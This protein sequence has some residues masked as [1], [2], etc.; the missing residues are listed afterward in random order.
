MS[1]S[2]FTN[3][4]TQLSTNVEVKSDQDMLTLKIPESEL[5]GWTDTLKKLEDFGPCV[6][7]SHTA[8][9]RNTENLF[10]VIYHFAFPVENKVFRLVS[11]IDRNQ[12]ELSS[13]SHLWACAE[14][15]ERE[16]YDLFGIKYKNHPDLRRVFLDDDWEGFPLRKDYKDPFMLELPNHD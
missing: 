14:Y 5:L 12:A 2:H 13:L 7:M 9:D 11:T 15:Q 3:I 6:L 16:V 4:L 8:I 10:E 1:E